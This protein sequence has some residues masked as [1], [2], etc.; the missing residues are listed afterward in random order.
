MVTKGLGK[1]LSWYGACLAGTGYWV[2]SQYYINQVWYH[3][4]A[5]SALGR[6]GQEDQKFKVTFSLT[7][8]ATLSLA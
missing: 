1:Q 8:L 3:M 2:L 4:P 5:I 7:P 6:W